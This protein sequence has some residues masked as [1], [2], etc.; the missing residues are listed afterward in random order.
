MKTSLGYFDVYSTKFKI[1]IPDNGGRKSIG[2]LS[3]ERDSP[4]EKPHLLKDMC[5]GNTLYFSA[6]P[7]VK[8]LHTPSVSLQRTF[9]FAV[10]IKPIIIL[11]LI[12]S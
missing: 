6:P 1:F 10:L 8:N 7:H 11:T 4:D 9:L 12:I 3:V 2:S 5:V